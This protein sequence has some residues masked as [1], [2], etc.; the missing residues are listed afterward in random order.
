MR[1]NLVPGNLPIDEILHPILR[2]LKGL[3]IG[4]KDVLARLVAIAIDI[5]DN[6]LVGDIARSRFLVVL[7]V[8]L[9]A[10]VGSIISIKDHGLTISVITDLNVANLFVAGD[11]R[12][13][14]VAA[15][16]V[17]V[18][19]QSHGCHLPI[20]WFFSVIINKG[21]RCL[22]RFRRVDNRMLQRI[23]LLPV[24]VGNR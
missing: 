23:I 9:K 4:S 11:C 17:G 16:F 8:N 18:A 1:V 21:N 3:R 5:S 19:V 14:I 15:V 2:K 7:E 6:P 24:V 22:L 12:T 13:G 10:L 20:T